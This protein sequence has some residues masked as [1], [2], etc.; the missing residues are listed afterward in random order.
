MKT[1]LGVLLVSL[2]MIVI[3]LLMPRGD[4]DEIALLP[5]KIEPIGDSIRVFGLTLGQTT[6]G[7]AEQRFQGDAE[8]SLFRR[9]E[10]VYSMEAY[11]DKV[12]LA[13]LSA[14]MVLVMDMSQAQLA[15]IYARGARISTLGSGSNKVSLSTADLHLTRQTPVASITY[16]P[17]ISLKPLQVERAFGVPRQT[18]NENEDKA[19]WL[20][21]D[22]GLD[23]LLSEKEQDV[24]QYVKPSRFEQILKPLTL[25]PVAMSAKKS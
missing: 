4:V 7:V 12:E 24:L 17:S 18:I 1:A 8:V 19:H 15:E 10:N 13:G 6:L 20:Y 5:W 2:L 21:P 25:T 23:V 16:L 11:F 22:L 3:A 9:D 14:K